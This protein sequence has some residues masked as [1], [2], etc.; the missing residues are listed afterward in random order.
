M[1]LENKAKGFTIKRR[2]RRHVQ[3]KKNPESFRV[4]TKE[5][6]SRELSRRLG[7]EQTK[8]LLPMCKKGTVHIKTLHQ[9]AALDAGNRQVKEPSL[10]V[11]HL[12]HTYVGKSG[13][14]T[15]IRI[16]RPGRIGR[17]EGPG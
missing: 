9:E 15:V 1:T 3:K 2:T 14:Q 12:M 6:G 10:N 5:Q 7:L 17:E 13:S 4:G 16:K 8:K 11:V